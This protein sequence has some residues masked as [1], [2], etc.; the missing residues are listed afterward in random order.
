MGIDLK[1]LSLQQRQLAHTIRSPTQKYLTRWIS[2]AQINGGTPTGGRPSAWVPLSS[3]RLSPGHLPLLRLSIRNRRR[4]AEAS[5]RRCSDSSA[6]TTSSASSNRAF[7]AGENLCRRLP[8]SPAASAVAVGFDASKG[9]GVGPAAVAATLSRTTAAVKR[10]FV[11]LMAGRGAPAGLN[12][13]GRSNVRNG[14]Q[15]WPGGKG[16]TIVGRQ[17]VA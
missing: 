14:R 9:S 4:S 17:D 16:G 12:S 15:Y 1:H 7:S 6:A 10:R 2:M 13:T 11:G 5:D 8:R 3:R